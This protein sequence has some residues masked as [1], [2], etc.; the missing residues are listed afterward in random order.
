MTDT[1]YIAAAQKLQSLGYVWRCDEWT[2]PDAEAA[3]TADAERYR[4]LRDEDGALSTFT[5]AYWNTG[6]PEQLDAAIDNAMAG[7]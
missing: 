2:R 1:K 7:D 4:W 5:A 3:R 6:T